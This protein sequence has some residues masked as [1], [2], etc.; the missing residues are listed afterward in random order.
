[1]MRGPQ[2]HEFLI[3]GSNDRLLTDRNSGDSLGGGGFVDFINEQYRRLKTARAADSQRSWNDYY[4]WRNSVDHGVRRAPLELIAYVVRNDLPYTEILTADYIMANPMAA[5]AYGA[6]TRFDAPEDPHEFRR[7]RIVSYYRMG[8]GYEETCDD[9]D[10][11]YVTDP[12][13]LSTN[14]PHAGILNTLAF[15][16]RYPTTATNRNRARSR[17]TYYH[18]LGLDVEKSASRT[19]D[20][21]ALED[22]D[23]PTLRNPNCTVCHGVL[24]P[25]A[26]AF[27]NYGDSGMYKD[28]WGG[29]DSLDGF[30]KDV[31]PGGQDVTVEALSWN[32]RRTLS[33]SG[34]LPGGETAI[35]LQAI[36]LHDND[37]SHR[38]T[39]SLGSPLHQRRNAT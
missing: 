14:Y 25:V 27:Q 16:Q 13:P 28:Q 18:F 22:T 17:W 7:S 1:L 6:S 31:P 15:L 20:P 24:D 33:V 36:I 35:G 26:G 39:L 34:W 23:N 38:K 9:D 11:C 30:Y 29:L 37:P 3:R 10:D 32:D 19:T 2:F 4:Y 12:G 21:E 5:A 8:D